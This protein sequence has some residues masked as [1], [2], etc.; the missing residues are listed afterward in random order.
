M[1]FG[2]E[3]PLDAVPADGQTRAANLRGFAELARQKGIDPTRILERHG[4]EA[5]IISDPDAYISCQSVVDVFEYCSTLFDDSLFG[6][7]FANTQDADVF[8][9]VTALC[10]AASTVREAVECMVTYF[11]VVHS[12]NSGVE[13]IEGKEVA[14][15]RWNVDMD[16]GIN[17]QAHYQA[18]VLNLKLLRAI[19][20]DDFPI[21]YVHLTADPQPKDIAEIEAFTGCPLRPRARANAI[22][23]PVQQLDQAVT[24]SNRLLFRLVSGYL[25]RVKN[26]HRTTITERVKSYVRGALPSGTCNIDRCAQKLGISVRTLQARLAESEVKF[27]DIVESQRLRFAKTFL[28]ATSMS[29]DEIAERLGYA[30]QTSFGRAFKRWTGMTPQRYRSLR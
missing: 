18:L 10:R 14:E 15:L 30:E 2:L 22:G 7:H 27:S 9:C 13:L 19:G 17:E 12:P 6:F 21:S 26:A 4:L 11:P 24:S 23:F 25:D 20:G 29:L 8:G 16:L 5:R 3:G 1:F 28:A